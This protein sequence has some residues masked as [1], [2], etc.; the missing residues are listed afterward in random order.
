M[1]RKRTQKKLRFNQLN[2][3]TIQTDILIFRIGRRITDFV[4]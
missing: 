2:L 3:R 1:R 4:S